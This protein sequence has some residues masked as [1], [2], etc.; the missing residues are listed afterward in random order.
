MTSSTNN[1]RDARWPVAYSRGVQPRSWPFVGRLDEIDTVVDLVGS[2]SSALIA[3]PAGVGKTKLLG[4]AIDRL[5]RPPAL[6]IAGAI[7]AAP[8]WPDLPGDDNLIV[9][10]DIH[11]LDEDSLTVIASLVA[12]G[13]VSMLATLRTGEE[14]SPLVTALWKDEHA[15]RVDVGPLTRIDIDQILDAHLPG[16]IDVAARL[17]LWEMSQGSPLV[18][19]ELVRSALDQHQLDFVDG[20]WRLRGRPRSGRLEDLL[21]VRL[22]VLDPIPRR[23]VEL[24]ALGSPLPLQPL[25]SVVGWSA[26]DEAARSELIEC[27]VDERRRNAVIAHPVFTDIVSQRLGIAGQAVRFGE[28]LAMIEATPMRRADDVLRAATWQVRAGGST[29]TADATLAARRALYEHDHWLAI[30]LASRVVDESPLAAHVLAEALTELGD[31]RQAISAVARGGAEIGDL[32]RANLASRRAVTLFWGFGDATAA[33]RVLLDAEDAVADATAKRKVRSERAIIAAAEGRLDRAD[34]LVRDLLEDDSTPQVFVSAV[35]AGAIVRMLDGRTVDAIDLARRGHAAGSPVAND[36]YVADPSIHLVAESWALGE[37]GALVDAERTARQALEFSAAGGSRTGQAWF[38]LV[39]GRTLMLRGRP[40]EARERFE[41]A[42]AAFGWLKNAAPRRW[43][44]AGVIQ[45]AALVGDADDA[46]RAWRTLHEVPEHPAAML[47]AEIDRASAWMHLLDGDRVEALS[48]LNALADSLFAAGHR[49]LGGGVVHDIVR[50][51][52]SVPDTLVASIGSCQGALAPVR[53]ALI[54][55]LAADQA[56]DAEAA[57]TA[58]S[59]LG[60]DGYAAEVLL[61]AAEL[62]ETSGDGPAA[63]RCRATATSILESTGCPVPVTV[64]LPTSSFDLTDRE[65]EI[66]DLVVGGLTNRQIAERLVVSVRTV[67]NHLHH[68]Y[69][70][71]NVTSREQLRTSRPPITLRAA[72][73]AHIRIPILSPA[74]DPPNLS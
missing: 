31:H 28:L 37:A 74:D 61:R 55:A 63:V 50:L 42:A 4:A 67:E 45:A 60:A 40:V 19:R 9:V 47:D 49:T 3:G 44:I 70:K 1:L 10:D 41:E 6:R 59:E 15:V 35:T 64:N 57:A 25:A 11:L 34:A 53:A 18:L 33:E 20:G 58:C 54:A 7:D 2:E 48:E 65:R 43:S 62:H 14:A 26:I 17:T 73:A 23:A 32:D 27:R 71:L 56:E 12:A 36:P 8:R 39:L 13:R 22:E 5:Q 51:G 46:R 16:P 38:A 24:V 52:G 30:D 29:V 72:G 69:Q 66:A 21:A 68:V